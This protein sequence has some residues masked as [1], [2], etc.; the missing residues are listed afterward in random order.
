VTYHQAVIDAVT[1]Q[2]LPATTNAELR[3]LENKVAPNFVAHLAAG[4]NVQ[5]KLKK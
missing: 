4:K 5:Q 2:L 1:K 3:D